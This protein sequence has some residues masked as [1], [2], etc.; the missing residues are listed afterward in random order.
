MIEYV[1]SPEKR[2]QKAIMG[3]R[4]EAIKRSED[5]GCWTPSA[6]LKSKDY[7]P[8]SSCAVGPSCLRPKQVL[9]GYEQRLGKDW[10]LES[11]TEGPQADLGCPSPFTACLKKLKQKKTFSSKKKRKSKQS[12]S[13]K[14]IAEKTN[15]QEG[16]KTVKPEISGMSL[17]DSHI[18]NMNRLFLL[19]LDNVLPEE[20]WEIG[21]KLGVESVEGD[22]AVIQYIREAQ[23]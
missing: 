3:N 19:K 17:S 5:V 7:S 9:G 18:E 15:K 14:K 2:F 8:R 12:C 21:K 11:G 13:S 23:G 10:A 6:C 16:E 1:S 20:T 4:T 22:V